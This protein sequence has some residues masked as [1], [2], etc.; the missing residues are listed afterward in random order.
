[1]GAKR[2]VSACFTAIEADACLKP[3]AVLLD[4]CDQ[5]CFRAENAGRQSNQVVAGMV[6]LTFQKGIF[7]DFLEAAL[8]IPVCQFHIASFCHSR[9]KYLATTSLSGVREITFFLA[10]Q[11]LQPELFMSGKPITVL[12]IMLYE[13]LKELAKFWIWPLM[14]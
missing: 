3:L 2:G 7:L 11:T 14:F 12:R 5:G 10:A 1:M 13:H 8:L 4:H 9:P 6:H